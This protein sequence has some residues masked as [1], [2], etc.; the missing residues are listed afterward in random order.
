[1]KI[2]REFK[3]LNELGR[4][5][6]VGCVLLP[7]FLIL[8]FV[9]AFFSDLIIV[10][11]LRVVFGSIFVLFLPGFVFSYLF[12]PETK[13]SEKDSKGKEIDI[14]ERTALSFALSIAIV[15]LFAF[16][17]NLMGLKINLLNSFLEI[18]FLIIVSCL[19]IY[20]RWRR[21]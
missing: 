20:F 9:L 3:Y 13:S 5:L 19:I 2:F 16:Y 8:A 18:L 17:L 15:P 6:I 12:F 10:D 1:M 4:I 11:S 7:I 21:K 14:L